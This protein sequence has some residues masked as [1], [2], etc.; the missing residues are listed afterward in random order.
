MSASSPNPG[1]I[2]RSHAKKPEDAK[3][4]EVKPQA[5]GAES[6]KEKKKR[7]SKATHNSSNDDT[8]D[9]ETDVKINKPGKKK[10]KMHTRTAH[11][12]G[13]QEYVELGA[14]VIHLFIFYYLVALSSPKN[15]C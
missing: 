13:E 1:R 2:L 4:K 14:K 12:D 7:K 9:S 5:A 10:R 11:S 3:E 6:E 8:H 15:I